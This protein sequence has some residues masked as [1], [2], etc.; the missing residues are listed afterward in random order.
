M[1][2][3]VTDEEVLELVLDER[4]RQDKKWGDQEHP[5]ETWYLIAGEE[6]GEIGKAILELEDY[7]IIAEEVI[8]LAAVLVNFVGH[9]LDA[10]KP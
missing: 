2:R 4:R 9:L 8:Q 10:S 3:T 1:V 6:F 5:T 7:D